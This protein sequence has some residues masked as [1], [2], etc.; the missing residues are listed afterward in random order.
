[1]HQY[2]VKNRFTKE[3]QF[4]AEIDCDP[5]AADSV[6]LGLAVRWAV[7]NKAD[8]RC[9]D[10]RCANLRGYKLQKAPPHH[11]RGSVASICL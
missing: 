7:A 1:M 3:V 5:N 11:F 2:P 10:L 4:I 9:A 8:L 6:K